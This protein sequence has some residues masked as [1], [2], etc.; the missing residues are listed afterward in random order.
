MISRMRA[1]PRYLP[2]FN[3]EERTETV[4]SRKTSFLFPPGFQ[5]CHLELGPCS[6]GTYPGPG[7]L[8]SLQQTGTPQG[9]G[10]WAL[11]PQETTQP[12]HHGPHSMLWF[13]WP[14]QLL[15]SHPMDPS[16]I[17]QLSGAGYSEPVAWAQPGFQQKLREEEVILRV[18]K[19]KCV[20]LMQG[21]ATLPRAPVVLCHLSLALLSLC[22]PL[23]QPS[24]S[25]TLLSWRPSWRDL[26]GEP[27]P[28]P[29]LELHFL[30]WHICLITI[31]CICNC[32]LDLL[33]K[34]SG[35]ISLPILLAAYTPPLLH[36]ELWKRFSGKS[37]EM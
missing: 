3:Y 26:A 6:P 14:S 34:E 12:C 2:E 25:G 13:L 28:C 18:G 15:P 29:G 37:A 32:P 24:C 20:L 10:P 31:W 7:S 22:Q 30:P 27:R 23:L 4:N 1:S 33:H 19:L 8:C 35:K 5:H 9:V 36:M 21:A 17:W 11:C 16:T